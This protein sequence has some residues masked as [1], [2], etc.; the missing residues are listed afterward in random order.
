MSDSLS[1][2]EIVPLEVYTENAYLNYSMYVI[3]DR[4]LPNISDGLKPVQRRIVYAM[5]ELGL[6]A[7]SKYKKSARTI[8]DVLGKFH[9]HGDSACYEAMVL[10]A[11][12]FSFRYPLVD[13]QGNWGSQDDPKSFAAM[14]YTEAKLSAFAQL[15]LAELNQETVEWG[16][17]F[18]GTL[19][20]PKILPARVP[21][22][23][24]NGGTGI[25]VGM[26]TD[27]PSHNLREVTQACIQLLNE[28]D[29]SLDELLEYIPGPDFPTH[30]EIITPKDELRKIY[31]T[32]RGTFKMRATYLMEES[33]IV[34]HALPHQTSAN[35]ILEQIGQ[36]IQNKKLPMVADLRD[37]SDH[38]HPVRI[39]IEPRSNRINV[40]QLMLHLFSSTD[41]QKNYRV[42]MNV[43]GIDG[44]P[45]VKSL[46]EMLSEW[47][48]FRLSTVRKRFEHRL[49]EVMDRLH[50]L[51]GLLI[52]YLNLDEVIRIIRQEEEPKEVLM[53]SFHL[54]DI[55]A[56]AILNLRLRYLA[57]LE[58]IKITSEQKE[59]DKERKRIESILKSETKL[60]NEI[61]QEL[62][63]DTQKHGDA[64][65]TVLIERPEAKGLDETEMQSIDAVTVILSKKGWVRSA[66]GH[67]IDGATLSFKSGD[68]FLMLCK[69]KSNQQA[70]FFDSTGRGYALNIADLP[71]ARGLGEPLTSHVSPP[72]GA[73]FISLMIGEQTQSVLL[74]SNKGYGFIAPF[75][76]MGSR[77]KA[78][79]ALLTIGADELALEPVWVNEGRYVAV[80]SGD[81]HLLVF[82][83]E[84][85]PR[86]SK[87]KGVK[88]ISLS[89][90]KGVSTLKAAL[91][92]ED[93]QGLEFISDKKNY[94]LSHKELKSYMGKRAGKGEKLPKTWLGINQMHL[95]L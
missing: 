49:K 89:D 24:L 46:K 53:A 10:M 73:H 30:A 81:D 57:K 65:R 34:I 17:N 76:E 84:D 50:I 31:E 92:L 13:G 23:L 41:L 12:P 90:K 15:L 91:V 48:V 94:V 11:Q 25:A 72:A 78:G 80:L 71:S 93:N 45:Q 32:G 3:L 86:M 29:T 82:K 87:G 66:K 4:A 88:L 18:D 36:Q 61:I 54:S 39:V 28:P 77:N 21:H 74:A 26:S 14:R 40:E 37:E 44:K 85:L 51:D 69:G 95:K 56:E 7:Q 33:N 64:R 1:F 79:K 42:N 38:E 52:S 59:L 55:Q 5:S 43:I 75:G 8:G 22:V 47:L 35:R 70:I 19:L 2:S 68:E 67:E 63:H 6:N 27:I 20:E 58:E 62:N 9:P 16:A 60:K 83:S